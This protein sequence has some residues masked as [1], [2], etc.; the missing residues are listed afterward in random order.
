MWAE[1]SR[2]RGPL[3]DVRVTRR[4]GDR[5]TIELIG[6]GR[7]TMTHGTNGSNPEKLEFAAAKR[8]F[9]AAFD[10]LLSIGRAR[11]H[12]NDFEGA[13]DVHRSEQQTRMS[14]RDRWALSDYGAAAASLMLAT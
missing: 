9:D 3:N 1:S 8:E 6:N 13:L 2:L 4:V 7:G 14:V 12:D 11:Y 5:W 10:T